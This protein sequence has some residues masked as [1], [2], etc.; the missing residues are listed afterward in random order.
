MEAT[1]Y[2]Q[3]GTSAGTIALPEKLFAAKWNADLVHQVAEA[4]MSNSRAGT[5][6]TKNRAEVRGGGK[7][8]WKQKGTGR[9]R[10][11]STRS[12]IWRGGGITHGPRAE[13]NYKKSVTKKMKAVA[14]ASAL[15]AKYKAGR[16]IFVDSLVQDKIK[17]KTANSVMT[18]L[19]KVKGF[20]YLVKTGKTNKAVAVLAMAGRDE[21]SYKSF[22]NLPQLDLETVSNLNVLDILNRRY[23]I[24]EN[25]TETIKVLEARLK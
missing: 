21:K 8:P 7:K 3:K 6:H 17:T 18:A 24:I 10:H 11:G 9:A 1:I 25:P 12:P 20:E 15:S 4:M 13:K 5:A 23:L 16:I 22:R 2:N 19:G 14:F